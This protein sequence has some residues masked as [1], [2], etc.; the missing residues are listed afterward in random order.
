M[1]QTAEFVIGAD[2]IC[3]DGPC[4][5]VSRVVVNPVAQTVTHLVVEPKHRQGLGRLVPLDLIS[6]TPHQVRLSCSQAEFQRLPSAEETQ[7]IPGTVGYA[8]YGPSQILAWPYYGLGPMGPAA[9]PDAGGPADAVVTYD[10]VPP[11][12]IAVHRGDPVQATD[13]AI[14]HVRGLVVDPRS[15]HVTHVLLAE[16]HLW[17]RK[18]VSIP[19]R[20]VA[21]GPRTEDG[22][23][24]T[25]TK[26]QVKD[27]PAV[28]IQQ[29]ND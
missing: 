7:F 19:V 3:T 12:E 23:R 17:G 8:A 24:L 20:A 25:I 29:A 4:G 18:Q 5:Q 2:A 9:I 11:G 27:L 6:G 14:G 28:D 22:I 21:A 1:S 15:H 10:A 13:G 26:D 16:G